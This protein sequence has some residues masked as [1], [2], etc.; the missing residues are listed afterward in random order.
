MERQSLAQGQIEQRDLNSVL[1]LQILRLNLIANLLSSLA[2]EARVTS[3]CLYLVLR[4]WMIT[5]GSTETERDRGRERE[6][7]ELYK[8][9][10]SLK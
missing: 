3:I 8:D 2:E 5:L 1:Q 10:S 7:E 4:E 9:R 6:R